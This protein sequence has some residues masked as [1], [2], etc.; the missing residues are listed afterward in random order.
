MPGLDVFFTPIMQPT[1]DPDNDRGDEVGN[2]TKDDDRSAS[3]TTKA[4]VK[5]KVRADG[6][7]ATSI[8]NV[9]TVELMDPEVAHL[10]RFRR[11]RRPFV[12]NFEPTEAEIRS[13]VNRL[14]ASRVLD[15]GRS[16]SIASAKIDFLSPL[17]TRTM[18][19]APIASARSHSPPVSAR[20]STVY[21]RTIPR[22][23]PSSSKSSK[24]KTKVVADA[25]TAVPSLPS[26]PTPSYRP[27]SPHS[28]SAR[29]RIQRNTPVGISALKVVSPSAL[30][31]SK[32]EMSRAVK[33]FIIKA[34]QTRGMA[35]LKH[36]LE[37]VSDAL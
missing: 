13:A 15:S 7:N 21:D 9:N 2:E 31:E 19:N 35:A 4:R 28:M 12:K 8:D 29:A 20:T 36:H 6:R 33:R 32:R 10:P 30:T 5:G 3:T 37:R 16:L 25:P 17:N 14:A 22:P 34:G 18:G 11:G 23:T 27:S 24:P 1:G 26:L